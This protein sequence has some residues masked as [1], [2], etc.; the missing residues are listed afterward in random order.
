MDYDL[1][2]WVLSQPHAGA[3][4]FDTDGG[5]DV[6]SETFEAEQ[7]VELDGEWW[8]HADGGPLRL[9]AS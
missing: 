1:G 6:S 4:G 3:P 5:A 9:G 7:D 2:V 8:R